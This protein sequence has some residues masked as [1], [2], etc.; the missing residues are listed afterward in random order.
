MAL[1]QFY[2][3]HIVNNSG[4]TVTFDNNGRITVHIQPVFIDPATGKITYSSDESLALLAGG[5]SVADGA[6]LKTDE[7]DNSG[8]VFPDALVAV[9]VTHDEGTAADGT[10]DIFYESHLQTGELPSD[11]TGFADPEASGLTSVGSL[12]WEPNGQDDEIME[13]VEHLI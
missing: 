9:E 5:E 7:Q 1:G 2:R 10:F 8:N 12:I 3:F 4:Q 6:F 13:S 11:Q